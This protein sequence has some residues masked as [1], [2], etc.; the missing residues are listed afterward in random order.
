MRSIAII[1]ARSGSKGL[2]DKNIADVCGRPL[3]DYT[4]RAALESNCFEHVMVSTDSK[5]YAD[6]A[7]K[8]GVEVPFLRSVETSKDTSDSWDVVRE[9]LGK[10]E[11]KFDYVMLLQPTSPLRTAEDIIN[12]FKLLE[13]KEVTNVVSVTEVE[14]PVQWCFSLENTLSLKN[15]AKSPFNQMRRQDLKKHYIENGA[16]YLVKADRIMEK[17]YNLYEDN[18]YAYIMPRSKSIDIDDKV[19]LMILEAILKSNI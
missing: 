11:K 2:V 7:K 3:I 1:P 18:C 19:D 17:Y 9:V 8:C 4:I 16:I 5:K 14:H 13:K 10:Y 15:Y 12:A 6:I